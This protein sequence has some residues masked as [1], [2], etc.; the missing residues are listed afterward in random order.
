[1]TDPHVITPLLVALIVEEKKF[2]KTTD[3]RHC[4]TMPFFLCLSFFGGGAKIFIILFFLIYFTS[5][6]QPLG[7]AFPTPPALTHFPLELCMIPLVFDLSPKRAA[8]ITMEA[9]THVHRFI[10]RNRKGE[11]DWAL[12]NHK[13]LCSVCHCHC[14]N[15]YCLAFMRSST[16]SLSSLHDRTGKTHR[17]IRLP[18]GV[19]V[20]I[21]LFFN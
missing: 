16:Q 9:D 20:A 14:V 11:A 13:D 7:D 21:F 19:L 10:R 15:I 12:W 8:R 1:M 6:Q 18:S 5:R 17:R 3:N 4:I 2:W